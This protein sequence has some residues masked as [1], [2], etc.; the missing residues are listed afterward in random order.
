MSAAADVGSSKK[1]RL[2]NQ[3]TESYDELILKVVG[4]AEMASIYR[5]GG[6]LRMTFPRK[7]TAALEEPNIDG[8]IQVVAI[9]TNAGILITTLQ[10]MLRETQLMEAIMKPPKKIK[11]QY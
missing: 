7:L 5:Y 6:S 3:Q 10:I 9:P 2:K 4:D 11:T 1:R 8:N